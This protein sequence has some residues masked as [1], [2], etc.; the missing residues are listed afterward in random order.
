MRLPLLLPFL[1][2]GLAACGSESTSPS[3]ESSSTT[4]E[5]PDTIPFRQDG[6]L[7]FWFEGE[8][9]VHLAIEIADND[10]TRERGLMQRDH[11]PDNGAMLFVF[12]REEPQGFWM[13]NTQM[14]LDLV[15]VAA[16]SQVVHV[17]KY[18]RPLSE[19][20]IPSERPAKYVVE[21]PAGFAD[22]Y[23]INEDFRISWEQQ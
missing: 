21:V 4:T 18:T 7:D 15:F 10:S 8:S 20:I 14:A 1:L 9:V 19:K 22:T 6:T 5:S 16:D 23:G 11:L 12:E 3:S 13:G 2:F 17:A